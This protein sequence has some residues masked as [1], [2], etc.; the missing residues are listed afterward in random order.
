MP[1][2]LQTDVN[3]LSIVDNLERC[4]LPVSLVVVGV[5][6]SSGCVFRHRLGYLLDDAGIVFNRQST[7]IVAIVLVD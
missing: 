7:I 3:G 4:V 5:F 6:L 1:V 2:T